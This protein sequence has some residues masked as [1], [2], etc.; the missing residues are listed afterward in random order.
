MNT[1]LAADGED[2]SA[3]GVHENDFASIAGVGAVRV[4]SE[5]ESAFAIVSSEAV[6]GEKERG[7]QHREMRL[8]FVHVAFLHDRAALRHCLRRHSLRR[9]RP[10]H[11]KIEKL[12]VAA[13]KKRR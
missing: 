2:A 6:A 5:D 10:Q 8:F 11:N 9:S 12:A 1:Y 4:D 3:G 13:K 7:F